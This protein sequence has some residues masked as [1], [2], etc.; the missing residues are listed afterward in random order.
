M[1]VIASAEAAAFNSPYSLLICDKLN[2][3]LVTL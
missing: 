2:E 1:I 3:W